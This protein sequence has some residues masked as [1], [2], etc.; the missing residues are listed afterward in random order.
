MKSVVDI[1]AEKALFSKKFCEIK[2]TVTLFGNYENL[3]F[4]ENFVKSTMLLLTNEGN[5][6]VDCATQGVMA[7]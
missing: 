1:S 5:V 4:D 7:I 6:K 2:F 3:L